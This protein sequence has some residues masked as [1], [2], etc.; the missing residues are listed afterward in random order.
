MFLF[1]CT[2]YSALWNRLCLYALRTI[3][4]S[5]VEKEYVES[6]GPQIIDLYYQHDVRSTMGGCPEARKAKREA[7]HL[8]EIA[9]QNLTDAGVTEVRQKFLERLLLETHDGYLKSYP[10]KKIANLIYHL[11]CK[12]R[13]GTVQMIF[14]SLL[15]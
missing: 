10:P 4:L 3:K 8:A 9:K 15:A 7:D 1:I 12:W 11:K 5:S 6:H 2:L 14:K 13:E